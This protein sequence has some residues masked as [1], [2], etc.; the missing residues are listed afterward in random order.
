MSPAASVSSPER[1]ARKALCGLFLCIAAAVLALATPAQAEPQPCGSLITVPKPPPVPFPSPKPAPLPG[2][3]IGGHVVGTNAV[4]EVA[5]TLYR[6]DGN[7]GMVSGQ[8]QADATGHF[9]FRGLDA[10]YDYYV[11]MAMPLSAIEAPGYRAGAYAVPGMTDIT[12]GPQ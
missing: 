12:I 4:T 2:G 11:E 3:G 8:M 10:A 9:A 6:C 5:V 7:V 1:R